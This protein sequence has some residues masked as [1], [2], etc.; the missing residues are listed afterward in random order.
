[1]E[2]GGR[3]EM[4]LGDTPAFSQGPKEQGEQQGLS[5]R[6]HTCRLK[7]MGVVKDGRVY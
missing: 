1:M 6:T 5:L 4:S 2:V 3:Q 7:W